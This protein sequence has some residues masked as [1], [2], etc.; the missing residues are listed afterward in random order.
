MDTDIHGYC[1]QRM[2]SHLPWQPRRLLS[3]APHKDTLSV[4]IR[5]HPWLRRV[6]LSG[7]GSA[8]KL[9]GIDQDLARFGTP[10]L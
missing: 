5:V 8:G 4:S 2:A 9:E 6:Q 3:P 7:S 10:G 1:R